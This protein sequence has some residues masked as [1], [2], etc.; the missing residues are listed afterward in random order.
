MGSYAGS[1][2]TNYLWKANP[3]FDIIVASLNSA[4]RKKKIEE[5]LTAA[6][7]VPSTFQATDM[8]SEIKKNEEASDEEYVAGLIE[9]FGAEPVDVVE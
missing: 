9:T 5:A 8:Q 3:G 7:G 6:A 1:N 2:G 4:E